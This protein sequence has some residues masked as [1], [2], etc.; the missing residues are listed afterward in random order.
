[1]FLYLFGRC[2]GLLPCVPLKQCFNDASHQR[3]GF[4]GRVVSGRVLRS[5]MGDGHPRCFLTGFSFGPHIMKWRWEGLVRCCLWAGS[6]WE[7]QHQQQQ[8]QRRQQQQQQQ[9]QRSTTHQQHIN[10]TSTTHQQHINNTST[11]HQQQH[12]QHINNTS[13]THQQHINNNNNTNS[14]NNQR[15]QQQQRGDL[16][17]YIDIVNWREHVQETLY[18]LLNLC[19]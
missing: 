1:M 13:T 3:A 5:F 11:T 2:Y 12:Q 8:Q 7:N 15:Q 17:P 16:S 14:N 9:Q 6:T 18:W 4:V 10:N 19:F